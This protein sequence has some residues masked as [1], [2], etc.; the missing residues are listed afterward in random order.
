MQEFVEFLA[1]G[2]IALFQ[3]L[4]FRKK[5]HAAEFLDQRFEFFRKVYRALAQAFLQLGVGFR[6]AVLAEQA[7]ILRA[8]AQRHGFEFRLAPLQETAAKVDGG[9]LIA[10]GKLF[11]DAQ[12]AGQAMANRH[13]VEEFVEQR[14]SERLLHLLQTVRVGLRGSALV[15]EIAHLIVH[16]DCLRRYRCG[17]H[18]AFERAA[19][20]QCHVGLAVGKGSGGID[21]HAVER[22]ALALVDGNRPS[23]FQG[24]L[25]K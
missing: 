14:K 20:A 25:A 16:N 4:I 1:N 3:F 2:C 9:A 19:T 7:H 10:I 22:Q 13:K 21:H 6:L 23:E 24:I 18:N 17:K 8:E 12:Q 11:K 5:C 15:L